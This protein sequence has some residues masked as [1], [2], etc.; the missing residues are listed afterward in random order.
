[1]GST[2]SLSAS[3]SNYWKVRD[4]TRDDWEQISAISMEVAKE[5]FVGDYIN[6]IGPK[7]TEIGRTILVEDREVIGYLNIQFVPDASIYLSGLR[8]KSS[9]RNKDVATEFINHAVR[10]GR[11]DGRTLAR[12]YVEPE[13]IPSRSLFTKA[14]FRIAGKMNLYFGS[15]DTDGFSEVKEWPDSIVD[16]GHVPSRYFDGVPATLLR[17]GAC[18]LAVCNSNL[19]DD[20]AT[21]TIINQ[22]DC[23]FTPGNAF[24]V[25]RVE[26]QLQNGPGLRIANGFETAYLFE[27]DLR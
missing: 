3:N 15:V 18:L 21:F 22:E 17:K 1:M 19:W 23:T 27:K 20:E 10:L 5:G 25:S 13:N 6:D 16:I 26:I 24:I 2:I 12:A 14:G 4:A 8:V 7:Y 11:S 9:R